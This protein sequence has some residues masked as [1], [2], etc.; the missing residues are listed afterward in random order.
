LPSR[1][2]IQSPHDLINK[3]QNEVF[4]ISFAHTKFK[5]SFQKDLIQLKIEIDKNYEEY[6][7]NEL[8]RLEKRLKNLMAS[9]ADILNKE[10]DES[11][12]PKSS[13]SLS[14]KTSSIDQIAE[15]MLKDAE[16]ARQ[17]QKQEFSDE[18]VYKNFFHFS[19]F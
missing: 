15:Q 5:I 9:T 17:I 10:T 19:S 18:N 14:K 13:L 4:L 16:L 7:K 1:D 2:K 11:V 12:E 6:E 8:E 3:I